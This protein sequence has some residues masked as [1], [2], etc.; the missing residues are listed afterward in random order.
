MMIKTTSDHELSKFSLDG[1]DDSMVRVFSAT[2]IDVNPLAKYV[3]ASYSSG[4]TVVSYKYY[5]SSAKLSLLN[6][7]TLSFSVAQDTTFTSA[8]WS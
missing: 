1:N 8:E 2:G 6:T 7:I 3:E 4:D 5:E